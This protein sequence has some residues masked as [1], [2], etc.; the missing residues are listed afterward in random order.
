MVVG[1]GRE[2]MLELMRTALGD[3]VMADGESIT[4]YM[5]LDGLGAETSCENDSSLPSKPSPIL[6]SV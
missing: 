4:V 2:V 6:G 3:V 5:L 1:E